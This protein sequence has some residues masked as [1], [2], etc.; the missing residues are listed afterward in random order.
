M[1]SLF[2]KELTVSGHLYFSKYYDDEIT[3]FKCLFSG[4]PVNVALAIE[5][6]SIDHISEVNMVRYQLNLPR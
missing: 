2:M 4:P 5:V 6:A 1:N 3:P